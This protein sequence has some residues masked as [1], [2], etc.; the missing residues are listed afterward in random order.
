MSSLAE[1]IP[2]NRFL[3]SLTF[4]STGS[5]FSSVLATRGL[6]PP[7]FYSSN[8]FY[9]PASNTT[10]GAQPVFLSNVTA[11]TV[12]EF[13]NNVWGARNRVG[14]GLLYR[15]ARLHRLAE[16]VPLNRL[17]ISLKDLK[18][19][20]CSL[21]KVTDAIGTSSVFSS[22]NCSKIAPPVFYRCSFFMLLITLYIRVMFIK[23]RH[24]FETIWKF[25]IVI[26]LDD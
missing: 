5:V 2:W 21:F 19:P 1:S 24:L 16:S 10:I 7:F 22:S 3:G 17:L 9:R 14:I 8:W 15:P 26:G 6:A 20:F 23:I 11:I 25:P 4:T 18:Y 13:E 12:L